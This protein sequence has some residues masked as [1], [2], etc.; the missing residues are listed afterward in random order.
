MRILALEIET[1]KASATDFQPHLV[2]EAKKVFQEAAPEAAQTIVDLMRDAGSDKTK[3]DASK[4]VV[5]YSGM[6]EMGGAQA[7]KIDKIIQNVVAH[8]FYGDPI[9]E[10]AKRVVQMDQKEDVIDVQVE[11]KPKVEIAEND[12]NEV[13]EGKD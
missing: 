6:T 2:E 9:S 4:M 8:H 13:S 7:P 3:M 10:E 1:A 12:K 5:E 11:E